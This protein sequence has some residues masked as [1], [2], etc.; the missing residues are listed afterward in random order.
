MVKV[1]QYTEKTIIPHKICVNS[2]AVKS[3]YDKMKEILN[4]DPGC[5]ADLREKATNTI[6]A[7]VSH[8]Y[9]A[10]NLLSDQQ[11]NGDMNVNLY[12]SQ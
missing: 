11:T 12:I 5:N 3:S 2:F 9:I 10:L 1:T 4:L 8:V 7:F 6:C